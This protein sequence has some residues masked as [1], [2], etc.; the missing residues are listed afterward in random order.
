L[1]SGS[2]PIATESRAHNIFIPTTPATA[3]PTATNALGALLM[4]QLTMAWLK[5]GSKG[6]SISKK[7]DVTAT[8]PVTVDEE[9][10]NALA[11]IPVQRNGI[12]DLADMAKEAEAPRSRSDSTHTPTSAAHSR[13]TSPTLRDPPPLAI[14]AHPST[15][16]LQ[17]VALKQYSDPEDYI[18]K[19]GDFEF[20]ADNDR[21]NIDISAPNGKKKGVKLRMAALNVLKMKSS[22]FLRKHQEGHEQQGIP[23]RR[24]SVVL[25]PTCLSLCSQCLIHIFRIHLPEV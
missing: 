18:L 21:P 17:L 5:G 7:R 22:T 3:T 23:W 10:S 25:S 12:T 8:G 14:E 1:A 19:E 2:G 13:V 16:P 6:Q 9:V 20:D 24:D 4:L 15:Q 11:V